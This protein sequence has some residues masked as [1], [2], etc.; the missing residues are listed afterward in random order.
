[1]L[2]SIFNALIDFFNLV[3]SLVTFIIDLFQDLVY[4]I[5]LIGVF[6]V[7]IPKYIGWLPTT[8]VA[9]VTVTFSIVVVYKILGRE[10]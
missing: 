2:K 9:L 4:V 7:K 5:K 3:G 10:G 1:M 8:C 6:I